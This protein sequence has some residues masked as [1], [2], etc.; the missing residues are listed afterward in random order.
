MRLILIV[1]AIFLV[2]PVYALTAGRIYTE[3]AQVEDLK[4]TFTLILYSG[5]YADGLETVVFFDIEG[6]SVAFA[7]N[8]P[9]FAYTIKTGLSGADA[10][11]Y[12]DSFIKSLRAYMRYELR[13]VKSPGG[14]VLGYE[15]KPVYQPFV[16]GSLETIDISYTLKGQKLLITVWLKEDI[17][18]RFRDG[19][20]F[21]RRF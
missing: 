4:G 18:R 10:L 19:D 9:Q 17:R 21:E 2:L 7:P 8:A 1:L 5:N 20:F 16:Y 12:A 3:P 11:H 13:A 14:R 15:M 6:D